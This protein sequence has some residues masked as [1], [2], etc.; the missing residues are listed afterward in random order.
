MIHARNAKI[1][2]APNRDDRRKPRPCSVP[3]RHQPLVY[4][5]PMRNDRRK[6][7]RK[8]QFTE[9]LPGDQVGDSFNK[10]RTLALL[11]RVGCAPVRRLVD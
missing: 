4:R 3:S 7:R 11:P 1:G 5:F 9:R 6:K 8:S 2:L 10:A